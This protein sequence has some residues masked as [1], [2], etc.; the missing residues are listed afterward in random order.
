MNRTSLV[1]I[2]N[3]RRLHTVSKMR[4]AFLVI[5]F[6]LGG[7][8]PGWIYTD[9]TQPFCTDMR[10]T[11]TG[12][13]QG[14]SSLRSVNIPRVPGTRTVWSSN[15]IGAAAKREGIEQLAYCDRKIFSV[16][17]GIWGSDS[18]VVYG[19]EAQ[20]SKGVAEQL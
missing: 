18:I 11:V 19:R 7:C 15:A 12:E 2:Q 16:L 8:A 9:I 5:L 13:A 10:N 17:G 1:F 20:S 3:E 6:F 14:A 4:I